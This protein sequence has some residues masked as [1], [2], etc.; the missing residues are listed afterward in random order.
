MLVREILKRRNQLILTTH[1]EHVLY[2]VM[3]LIADGT[4]SP[5]TVNVFHVELAEGESR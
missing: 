1:S 3:R 4:L 2:A 5:D